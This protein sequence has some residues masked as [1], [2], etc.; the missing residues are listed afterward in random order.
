MTEAPPEPARSRRRPALV[1]TAVALPVTVLL[2]LLFARP[3]GDPPPPQPTPG[4]AAAEALPAVPVE[5]PP[6]LSEAA[7]RACQELIAALPTTLGDRPARP[8]RSSS[9]YVAAWG[10][11]AVVL[12]CGVAEP[13]GFLPDSQVFEIGGVR[14]FPVERGAGTVWTATDRAVYVEVTAPTAEASDPVAR[15]STAVTRALPKK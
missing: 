4:P 15:L 12:R 13:A 14:W 10:E 9:P 3:G 1:A 5:P 11:P 2:A 6:A 8:V 7:Q